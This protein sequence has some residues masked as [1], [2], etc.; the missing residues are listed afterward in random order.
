M[1]R[2]F[3]A[4]GAASAGLLAIGAVPAVAVDLLLLS[5]D[6]ETW[7]TELGEP[8]FD[9]APVLVPG[10]QVSA[11]FWVRNGSA[12]AADL[13][14]V[15]ESDGA[16][17]GEGAFWFRATADGNKVG[18]AA[19][20]NHSVLAVTDMQARESR[21]ITVTVGLHDFAG[22]STQSLSQ[23]IAFDVRLTQSIPLGDPGVGGD[24]G[25]PESAT[26]T[27]SGDEEQALPE[28]PFGSLADTGFSSFWIAI[29][30]AALAGIGVRIV[31]RNCR[32]KNLEE[33]GSHGA[34]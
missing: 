9:D 4:V 28:R 15:L 18:S 12:D 22:N 19:H 14:V 7:G 27:D 32:N 6:G 16:M 25:Q 13:S 30:G 34:A 26:R 23:P 10:D 3:W 29:F 17:E 8:L 33:E 11:D 1:R 20:T 24:D 21:K 2:R 31:A 5:S